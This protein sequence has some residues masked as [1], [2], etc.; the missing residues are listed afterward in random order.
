MSN[1]PKLSNSTSIGKVR[2]EIQVLIPLPSPSHH[3]ASS[4]DQEVLR[5]TSATSVFV[6]FCLGRHGV[7]YELNYR[8]ELFG[9]AIPKFW[10]QMILFSLLLAFT[11][12]NVG[13]YADQSI[14]LEVSMQKTFL[15]IKTQII[16][17]FVEHQQFL[18]SL[19]HKR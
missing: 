10:P 12:M 18:S 13:N 2:I 5:F 3:A 8:I 17:Y 14:N 6:I 19:L 9:L 7:I 16:Y 1:F 15:T 4:C 11:K